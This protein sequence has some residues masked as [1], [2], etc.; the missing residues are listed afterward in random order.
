MPISITLHKAMKQFKSIRD[1]VILL[2][3]ARS[4]KIERYIYISVST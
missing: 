4:F 1:G 3:N 2:D